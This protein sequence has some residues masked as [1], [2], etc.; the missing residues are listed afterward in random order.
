MEALQSL[1]EH[2]AS[3]TKPLRE[4]YGAVMERCGVLRNITGRYGTLR[5]VTERY[6]TVTEN[7][8]FAH[9]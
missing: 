4:R 2:Y 6:G 9:P 1:T 7:I 5:G 3:V 8:N